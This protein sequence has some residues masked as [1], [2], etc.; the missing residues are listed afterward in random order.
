[1]L[2]GAGQEDLSLPYLPITTALA[3][4]APDGG[5]T[6]LSGPLDLDETGRGAE[7][8]PAHLWRRAEQALLDVLGD[9]P[10]VLV[11]D[12][13][14]WAD[15]A[16]QSLLLHL[17][18]LLDHASAARRIRVLTILTVRTPV[19]DER[20]ARTVARLEREP[21]TI[22]LTLEGLSR[23]ELRELLGLVAPAPPTAALV[24][25][26]VES[27]G[28]NPLLAEEVLRSGLD[29][30]DLRVEA[31][32]LVPAHEHLAVDLRT[33]DRAVSARIEGVSPECRTLLT[34][35]ALLGEPHDVR[36][37]AVAA[38][39][40]MSD[41][42]GLL[43]EGVEAGI[44]LDRDGQ[45]A[46]AHPQ[47]RHVLFHTPS[48]RAR[49]RLHLRI[50]DRLEERGDASVAAI[51][52][53]LTRAG[54]QVESARLSRWSQLAAGQAL[55]IGAWS[56]AAIAADTALAALG[57]EAPWD[58]RAD[59]HSLVSRAA[60][61]DFDLAVASRHG[62]LAV[63]LAEAHGDAARWAAALI[64]LARTLA[65]NAGAGPVADPT[66]LLRAYLA[67]NPDADGAARA[68]VLA[69]LSEIRAAYDDLDG[70]AEAAAEAAVALPEDAAPGL[71]SSAP[72]AEGM[73]HWARLDLPSA[74]DAF[75]RAQGPRPIAAARGLRPMPRFAWRWSTSSSATPT[76][77]RTEPASW[78]PRCGT[79]RSG[80][81]TRC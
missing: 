33:F 63:D 31:G 45:V 69:L 20:V 24:E 64:P 65:T 35:A 73:A 66:S 77:W 80:A 18:V 2:W 8:D 62:G 78:P 67:A 74:S 12:D 57:P 1:M 9:K 34:T 4:I 25:L 39:L 79:N 23:P 71:A 32:S 61:H 3:T 59:L 47:V 55:A 46:F 22:T 37:L 75:Q 52:H 19:D 49:E 50:A 11:I 58:Q 43:E 38:D 40:P 68:E 17:L 42:D 81:S 60:S 26:V 70:A 51:A 56:D 29:V 27:S 76:W 54:S 21:S 6:S 44:L 28:G 5:L 16:S 30:K 53:H 36:D 7:E 15:P 14:Q 48:R 10:V 72:F 41:V 13:L